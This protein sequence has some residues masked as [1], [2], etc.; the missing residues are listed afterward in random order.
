MASLIDARGQRWEL[1]REVTQFAEDKSTS[2]HD[3]E[4]A[5]Q[6]AARWQDQPDEDAV[7]RLR[8][9]TLT[10][11]NL[12][13]ALDD[14]GALQLVQQLREAKQHVPRAGDMSTSETG[15][16]LSSRSQRV[17]SEERFPT[18][19]F[20]S[21]DRVNMNNSASEL[22]W[23]FIAAMADAGKCTAFKL[24]NKHT[25]V[26]AAHCVHDGKEWIKRKTLQFAA[27]AAEPR[28]KLDANCYSVSVPGGWDG[29][30]A[31]FDYA[32]IRLRE[33]GLD[34]GALCEL[35]GYDVGYFG[36]QV[37]DDCSVD[38][39]LNLAGYPSLTDPDHQVPAGDWSYP[40][41]FSD[42]R[43]DG[44][45]G[46]AG[47]FPS[48]LF[49]YNDGSNGQSGAPV[50]TLFDERGQNAVRAIYR[51]S[52]TSPVGDS[53]RGR[54]LDEELVAWLTFNAGY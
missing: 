48:A 33:D 53:N 29:T 3:D 27:G 51:G 22:P 21:D 42:H 10:P 18:Q 46:C 23:M 6:R 19:T 35:A 12:E 45:S 2:V 43:T 44:W 1:Q 20:A 11:G 25:A 38:V 50:W 32:V 47:L 41:L 28:S 26:T 8:P 17:L 24:L 4:T 14:E 31:E 13:Y 39:A 15:V 5:P 30:D 9:I 34:D 37:V 54:R 40:T 36:Y 52:V 49:F 16:V 7:R